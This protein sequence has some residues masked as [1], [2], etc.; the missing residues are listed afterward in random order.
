M[1]SQFLS[2]IFKVSF[3]DRA[4]PADEVRPLESQSRVP[5]QIPLPQCPL[6]KLGLPGPEQRAG[7]AAGVVPAGKARSLGIAKQS[8]MTMLELAE[9]SGEAGPARSRVNGTNSAAATAVAVPADGARPP[10]IT[11][12]SARTQRDWQSLLVELGLLGPEQ[13]AAPPLQQT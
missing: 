9:T 12:R 8:A 1:T 2:L 4:T 7:A 10:G 13:M 6:V 11:K 3:Q 5:R